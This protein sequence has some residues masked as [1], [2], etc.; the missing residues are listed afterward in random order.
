MNK[1]IITVFAAIFV[2]TAALFAQTNLQPLATVKLNK[3]ETIT[4]KQLKDR[5]EVYKKQT[6]MSSF[7]IEQK[8]EILDSL[9]NEKLILQAAAKMGMG[10]TD[11]QAYELYIQTLSSQV[12]QT[13]TEADFTQLVKQQY[14]MS[15]DDFFQA[16]L[17]M[18]V[19]DYKVF[20]KNQYMAQQYIMTVKQ[21]EFAAV[22]ATDEEIRA[23]YEMNKQSFY[24]NDIMK[25]FFVIV[26]KGS[27][28]SAAKKLAE[29]LYNDVIAKKVTLDELKIKMTDPK[30]GFQ[31]G[32]M[33]IS[34]NS[35]A[36]TQ[37][38]ITYQDLL[39]FF[40]RSVGNVDEIKD[41]STDYQFNII[42]ALYP[43][44]LLELSDIVQ[45]EST[46]TVYEYIRNYVS[47]QKMSEYF[48]Q[49][50]QEICDELRTSTNYQ[51]MK[52]GSAL[53]TLLEGW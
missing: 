52:T 29:S 6:S 44:K 48:N 7:T 34:K 38:G 33:F 31:A 39:K 28:A 4:L 19:E 47:Q 49:A 21:N 25:A 32:D 50:T 3:A 1:R 30:S 43:A 37:L 46:T 36:A 12:G 53:D 35:Q 27:D 18:S 51:M 40:T 16:Q 26:P 11:T 22:S 9:I 45:P 2:S 14:N 5:C 23:Y 24:Q 10:I 13:V 17:G 8:K 15:L 42:R 41:T 20:L